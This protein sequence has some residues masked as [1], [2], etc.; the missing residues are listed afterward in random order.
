M[1]PHTFL[2]LSEATAGG[3]EMQQQQ[4]QELSAPE[5]AELFAFMQLYQ[6]GLL[7]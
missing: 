5:R 2:Q 3:D 1:I 6:E 4:A 7:R